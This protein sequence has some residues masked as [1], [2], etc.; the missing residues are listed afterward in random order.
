MSKFTINGERRKKQIS[1]DTDERLN[2]I[3]KISND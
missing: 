1:T 3:R 2:G